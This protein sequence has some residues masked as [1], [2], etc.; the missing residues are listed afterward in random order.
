MWQELH[1]LYVAGRLC[2]ISQDIELEVPNPDRPQN[3]F[4]IKANINGTEINIEV[5]TRT[6]D[7]PF[8]KGFLHKVGNIGSARSRATVSPAFANNDRVSS[9]NIQHDSIPESED[10]R[11]RLLD[12]ATRQ[13][14]KNGINIIAL[15][16]RGITNKDFH[17]T[18]ALYG[19][20]QIYVN[21][22]NLESP[23][24]IG[25]VENGL[26]YYEEGFKHISAV[27]LIFPHNN[28]GKLYLNPN[29]A[30]GLPLS[31]QESLVEIFKLEVVEQGS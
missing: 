27:M 30:K 6:D 1:E 26:Y 8:D 14:P 9:T 20:Q 29:L 12:K 23:P 3:N 17:I 31:V 2:K 5:T 11:R 4:D 22:R 19:D 10:L 15:G 21:K 24:I 25:R 18:S 28:D 13:L 7:F 16:Y